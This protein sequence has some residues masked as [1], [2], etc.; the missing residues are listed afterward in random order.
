MI[1]DKRM[2]LKCL[3]FLRDE[4]NFAIILPSIYE[5]TNQVS[6]RG[7]ENFSPIFIGPPSNIFGLYY[8][9]QLEK[10]GEALNRNLC[11]N[12]SIQMLAYSNSTNKNALKFDAIFF[13]IGKHIEHSAE[14]EKRSKTG[15]FRA[16]AK[17]NT[18]LTHQS[19]RPILFFHLF[20]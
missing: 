12:F 6:Q 20:V 10:F 19:S 7:N 16:K 9:R 4:G 17:P 1:A 13:Q 8:V 5:T 14:T 2:L 18:Q 15:A 11:A 3:R